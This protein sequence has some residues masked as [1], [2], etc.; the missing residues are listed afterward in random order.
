MREF[1]KLPPAFT[2]GEN[3]TYDRTTH[4]FLSFHLPNIDMII[5]YRYFLIFDVWA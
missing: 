1:L 3:F 4:F 2:V 5:S